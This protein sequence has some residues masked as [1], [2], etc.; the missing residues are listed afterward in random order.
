MREYQVVD[1]VCC[2][3]VRRGARGAGRGPCRQLQGLAQH[4]VP[5]GGAPVGVQ[6]QRRQRDHRR[7]Q[8]R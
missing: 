5:D 6:Q 4:A 8:D 1:D 2:S 7:E 3:I